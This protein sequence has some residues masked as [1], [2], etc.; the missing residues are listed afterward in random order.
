MVRGQKGRGAFRF[1][2]FSRFFRERRRDGK[3][4]EE[5]NTRGNKLGNA[6]P[7]LGG[8]EVG[9]WTSEGLGRELEKGLG[10]GGEERSWGLL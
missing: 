10:I 5:C 6:A 8:K 2:L 3:D 9:S 4:W 1:F 7:P